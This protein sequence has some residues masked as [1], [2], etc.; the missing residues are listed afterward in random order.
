MDAA[1][2]DMINGGATEGGTQGKHDN[3]FGGT[4]T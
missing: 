2:A 3:T 4:Q 1:M